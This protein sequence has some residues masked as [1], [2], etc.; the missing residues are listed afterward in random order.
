MDSA[1]IQ[2][3]GTAIAGVLGA[4]GAV[5]ALTRKG[6]VD[7]YDVMKASEKK[8]RV[9][10]NKLYTYAS[11]LYRTLVREGLEPEPLPELEEDDAP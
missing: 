2:S 4:F 3:W 11:T 7:D 10:Y 5:Y 9:G 6:K 1:T 8:Y